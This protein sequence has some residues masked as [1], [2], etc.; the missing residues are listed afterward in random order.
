MAPNRGGRG[1]KASPTPVNKR[2]KTTTTTKRSYCKHFIL[3]RKISRFTKIP[4]DAKVLI[5]P[6]GD[7]DVD[8]RTFVGNVFKN[9]LKTN[10]FC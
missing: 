3:G 6:E 7:A 9:E 10:L 2:R 5:S 4:S 1:F 8:E